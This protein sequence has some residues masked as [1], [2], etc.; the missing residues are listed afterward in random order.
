MTEHISDAPRYDVAISFLS[1]HEALALRIS[2]GLADRL[3]AFVYS[4][5]QEEVVGRNT[6]GV[7]AFTN[8]FRHDS[9]V[10][11]V[12]HT[13]GWGKKGYTHIEEA[14]IKERALE[15]GWD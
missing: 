13:D 5:E 11:V 3:K 9:R 4:R 12:L 15:R 6:D 10:C 14:A 2:D 7:E 1:A 8:V